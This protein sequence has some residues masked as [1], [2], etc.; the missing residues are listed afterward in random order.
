MLGKKMFTPTIQGCL[1]ILVLAFCLSYGAGL[2]I[3]GRS[4]LLGL[5]PDLLAD[6]LRFGAAC[7][8]QNPQAAG[9]ICG[10]WGF[11]LPSYRTW[12]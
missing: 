1:N 5:L 9:I 10:A 3:Q 6:G 11:T 7:R 4:T 12:A 8:N 2:H